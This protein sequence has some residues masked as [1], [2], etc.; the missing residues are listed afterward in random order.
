[1]FPQFVVTNVSYVSR[2][3]MRSKSSRNLLLVLSLV[4]EIFMAASPQEAC[5]REKKGKKSSID[6]SFR[7]I[8]ADS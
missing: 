6:L 2:I 7:L 5:V 8:V 3:F 4:R 1:L